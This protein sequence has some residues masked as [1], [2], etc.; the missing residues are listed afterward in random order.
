MFFEDLQFTSKFSKNPSFWFLILAF[1]GGEGGRPLA[2]GPFLFIRSN[3][4]QIPLLILAYINSIFRFLKSINALK[5]PFQILAPWTFPLCSSLQTRLSRQTGPRF[6]TANSKLLHF[7]CRLLP[8]ANLTRNPT[9][10]SHSHE[11]LSRELSGERTDH[12][13]IRSDEREFRQ[14][15]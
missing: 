14:K 5:I 3:R 11:K 2:I 9:K 12:R 7:F 4:T 13:Y 6:C 1:F 10:M 15:M 8:T